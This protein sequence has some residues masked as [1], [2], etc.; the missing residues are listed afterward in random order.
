MMRTSGLHGL[1][2]RCVYFKRN[3]YFWY[4]LTEFFFVEV[5][6]QRRRELLTHYCHYPG[7]LFMI[8]SQ[9]KYG[10]GCE[11]LISPFT[12]PYNKLTIIIKNIV[13]TLVL[14]FPTWTGATQSRQPGQAGINNNK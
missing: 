4:H 2:G 1:C 13:N 11:L 8:Y 12:C 9:N 7:T 10:I 14:F 6:H 3:F 5:L